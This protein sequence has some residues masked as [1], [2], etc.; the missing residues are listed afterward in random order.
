M[1]KTSSKCNSNKNK[2]M[3]YTFFILV[4]IVV[5]STGCRKE[6][7]NRLFLMPFQAVD[8]TIPAGFP[9][10]QALVFE[11]DVLPTH[12]EELLSANGVEEEQI[13][14]IFPY[15]ASL[16]SLDGGEYY[17]IQNMEIRICSPIESQ[18]EPSFDAVFSATDLNGSANRD[19]VLFPG[20]QNKKEILLEDH[21]KMEVIIFIGFGQITPYT[22]DS[23]LKMVFE[24]TQ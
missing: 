14:G 21:I 13:G 8:F 3:R 17:Y 15:T 22:V 10:N 1:G 24:A 19:I 23:R 7:A 4:I 12:I 18:C 6:R 11:Y 20:L 5:V 2:T 9:S 16:E